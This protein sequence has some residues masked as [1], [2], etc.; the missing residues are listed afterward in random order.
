MKQSISNHISNALMNSC[1]HPS[2]STGQLILCHGFR[3]Y[4]FQLLVHFQCFF[5]D[6]CM[7]L[8]TPNRSKALAKHITPIDEL[9]GSDTMDLNFLYCFMII[10]LTSPWPCQYKIEAEHEQK[11]TKTIDKLMCPS[12]SIDAVLGHSLCVIVSDTMDLHLL[13]IFMFFFPLISL[14]PCQYKIV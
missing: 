14:W 1:A 8:P 10:S 3:Y 5:I 6:F 12:K 11:H 4:G 13:C 7:A 9:M 2:Q